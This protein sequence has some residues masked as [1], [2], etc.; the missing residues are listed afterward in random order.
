MSLSGKLRGKKP[1]RAEPCSLNQMC[2]EFLLQ[3]KGK[4]IVTGAGLRPQPA[5]QAFIKV[6]CIG[7]V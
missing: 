3:D 4:P 7:C 6:I 5:V 1:A 2:R